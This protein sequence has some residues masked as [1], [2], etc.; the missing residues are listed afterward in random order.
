MGPCQKDIIN[1][2]IQLNCNRTADYNSIVIA[3]SRLDIRR[4]TNILSLWR[5]YTLPLLPL[6]P[7]PAP[8]RGYNA[9]SVVAVSVVA[10]EVWQYRT[11][12]NLT[13]FA[14]LATL[15]RPIANSRSS[16]CQA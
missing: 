2:T 11:G 7:T 5:R 9:V 15:W 10:E 14:K 4:T 3:I 16:C 6:L 13:I 1:L 8:K 12:G